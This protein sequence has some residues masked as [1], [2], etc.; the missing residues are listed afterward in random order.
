MYKLSFA[1]VDFLIGTLHTQV[2]GTVNTYGVEHEGGLCRLV[3]LGKQDV[4]LDIVQAL[5]LEGVVGAGVFIDREGIEHALITL[6]HFGSE[7]SD[8]LQA[9]VI[10]MEHAERLVNL[11]VLEEL[12]AVIA[13]LEHLHRVLLGQFVAELQNLF[14]L[15]LFFVAAGQCD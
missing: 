12:H 14:G 10:L 1:L 2:P 5:Q 9:I 15:A 7:G 4:V 6:G 3:V 8:G 13:E 11:T